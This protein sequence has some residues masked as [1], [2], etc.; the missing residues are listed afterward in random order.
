MIQNIVNDR[1]DP[2]LGQTDGLDDLLRPIPNFDS[3]MN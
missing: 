2:A 1:P 3:V